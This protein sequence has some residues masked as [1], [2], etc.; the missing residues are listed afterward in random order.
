MPSPT[1]PPCPNCL[2]MMRGVLY[3][4]NNKYYKPHSE[5]ASGVGGS[6]N[7]G[8]LRYKKRRV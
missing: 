5:P 3:F 4:N 1:Q 8:L 2:P 6:C 7:R